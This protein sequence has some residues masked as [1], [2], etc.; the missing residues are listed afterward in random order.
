MFPVCGFAHCG[1]YLVGAYTII[2]A[3]AKF[4]Q[5]DS[6]KRKIQT[7]SWMYTTIVKRLKQALDG[8]CTHKELQAHPQLKAYMY[9]SEKMV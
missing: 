4:V 2:D 9:A 1:V 7:N 8:S 3:T 5:A 6:S